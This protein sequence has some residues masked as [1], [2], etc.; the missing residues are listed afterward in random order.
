[1]GFAPLV[2]LAGAALVMSLPIL[3]VHIALAGYA[4]LPMAAYLTSARLRHCTP[5][6]TRSLAD[7][8]LA[9]GCS[10]LACWSRIQAR[11]G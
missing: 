5:R 3:N 7:A 4:D 8:A 1:M 9:V 11:R 2:S 6:R 10:R